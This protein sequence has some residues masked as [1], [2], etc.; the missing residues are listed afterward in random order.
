MNLEKDQ[1]IG[2]VG[3]MGPEAGIALCNYLLQAPL[4]VEDQRHLSFM[5]MS[6]PAHITDRTAFLE[7]SSITNPAYAVAGIITRLEKA[8]A[9]IIAIA[10][11][12]CHAPEIYDVILGELVKMNSEVRL[13]HM[14]Y[15]TLSFVKENYQQVK[16]IGLMTTNGT[17]HSG[18]YEKLFREGGYEVILPDINLQNNCIHRMIYDPLTGIKANPNH[19]TYEVTELMS[20]AMHFFKS[21]GADA[22]VL[23]CTELSLVNTAA[24][25][26]EMPVIDAMKILSLA[27]IKESTCP[28]VVKPG[29]LAG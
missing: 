23:G 29:E 12:T 24:F 10:C 8:G 1:V 26:K 22:V 14:P 7:G 27:L 13:V 11:N 9:G 19:I 5:L 2:I 15:E 25:E 17:Y 20:E 28:G 3:G 6:F 4:A 21:K 16:R 18:V